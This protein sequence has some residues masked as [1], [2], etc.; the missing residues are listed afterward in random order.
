MMDD[1]FRDELWSMF[2]NQGQDGQNTPPQNQKAAE[3]VLNQ[4]Q[5]TGNFRRQ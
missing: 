2:T 5:A 1:S 4:L 3:D